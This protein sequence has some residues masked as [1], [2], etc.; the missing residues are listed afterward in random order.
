MRGFPKHCEAAGWPPNHR[1]A[2]ASSF[3]MASGQGCYWID[4]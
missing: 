4:P 3:K 1:E 2:D